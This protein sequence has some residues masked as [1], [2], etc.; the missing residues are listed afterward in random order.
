MHIE[1]FMDIFDDECELVHERTSKGEMH[2][3]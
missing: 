2:E 1:G 3:I